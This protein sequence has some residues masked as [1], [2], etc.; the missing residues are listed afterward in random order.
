TLARNRQQLDTIEKNNA[1]KVDII[2]GMKQ[3]TAFAQAE[4]KQ[5]KDVLRYLV[6]DCCVAVAVALRAG[7]LPE[8][9]R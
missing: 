9:L 8:Q 7:W 1:K 3:S 6:T 2:K 5:V 4:L